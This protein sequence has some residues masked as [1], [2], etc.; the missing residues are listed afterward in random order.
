MCLLDPISISIKILLCRGYK[1]KAL[2][3]C[4]EQFVLSILQGHNSSVSAYVMPQEAGLE[5]LINNKTLISMRSNF[6]IFPLF[7]NSRLFWGLQPFNACV[8]CSVMTPTSHEFMAVYTSKIG[9]D[10]IMKYDII[11]ELFARYT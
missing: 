8:Q 2:L 11:P 1:L 7:I 6:K 5:L 9:N 10:A 3:T 4:T